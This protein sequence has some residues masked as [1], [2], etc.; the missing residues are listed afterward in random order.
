MPIAATNTLAVVATNAPAANREHRGE[1]QR[2]G[3]SPVQPVTLAIKT[4]DQWPLFATT[5]L[6]L[7]PYTGKVLKKE[8]YSDQNLGRQVR[9]WTRFL[10]TG[11]A[12]GVVGKAV[13]GLASVGAL[14]LVWTG[15]ALT[16]R[17]FFFRQPKAD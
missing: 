11:E 7:D 6:T 9:S 17:R 5:Q 4:Q 2:E 12:L 15:F 13:A 8:G 1:G 16:W 3:R 14:L 10:H